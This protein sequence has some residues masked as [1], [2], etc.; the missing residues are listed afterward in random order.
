M[1]TDQVTAAAQTG[2][3]SE[4]LPPRRSSS[5]IRIY[6]NCDLILQRV[7][8]WCGDHEDNKTHFL[9]RKPESVERG[10]LSAEPKKLLFTQ[11][12]KEAYN[13][14]R[15]RLKAGIKEAKKRHQ[16]RLETLMTQEICGKFRIY[17]ITGYKSRLPPSCLP[18]HWQ[19]CSTYF[20]LTLISST[21]SKL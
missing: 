15:V 14:A 17:N 3:Y 6:F 5:I 9:T 20:I 13:T 11:M 1:W 19:M 10:G 18:A 8:C 12:K 2:T 4:V 21:N 16:H 7:C